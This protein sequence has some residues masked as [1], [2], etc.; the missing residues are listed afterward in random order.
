MEPNDALILLS[1]KKWAD[2]FLLM[3]N[4]RTYKKL[5][6]DSIFSSVFHD[7]FIPE[8]LNNQEFSTEERH[9]YLSKV[10]DLHKAKSNSFLL[11][12]E[13][14]LELTLELLKQN[15]DYH[16]AKQFPKHPY[17]KEIIEQHNKKEKAKSDIIREEFIL[18]NKLNIVEFEATGQVFS[19]DSIL[20]SPQELEF[21]NAAI[22]VFEE[23][24]ILPN[25]ALSTVVPSEIIPNNLKYDKWFYLTTTVDLVIVECNS[26]K[27]IYFFELDSKKHDEEHQQK[28]DK[29]K[30]LIINESGFKLHRVRKREN[31]DSTDY[32]EI[33]LR[34]IKNEG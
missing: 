25:A 16:L 21:C 14:H 13:Q 33:W 15:P 20:K 32:F 4:Q 23:Y 1:K 9:L 27:P 24:L 8:L 11:T 6:S 31:V 7:Y 34:K 29:V 26:F 5:M 12:K 10:N 30:N 18:R 3:E 2:V 28:K 19:K 22:K 17:C